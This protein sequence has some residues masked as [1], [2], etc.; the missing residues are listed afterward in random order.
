MVP[1]VF[2]SAPILRF[3]S[4]ASPTIDAV[5]TDVVA[6]GRLQVEVASTVWGEAKWQGLHRYRGQYGGFVSTANRAMIIKCKRD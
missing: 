2:K 4:L 5:S 6:P 3:G 1:H